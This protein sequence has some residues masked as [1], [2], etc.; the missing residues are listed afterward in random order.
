MVAVNR[1]EIQQIVINLLLNAEHAIGEQAGTIVMRTEA[2]D[3]TH[4]L[5]VIDSGPGI[6]PELRGRVFEPFFTTKE[7]GEGT[8]LGLSIA[9]GIARAHGGS[10]DLCPTVR[11]AC[12]Q[13]TL[14]ARPLAADAATT[15]ARVE[16]PA[17]VPAG[18]GA[19]SRHALVIDDEPA[20]R[21]LLTRLLANRDYSVT[22][23]RSFAEVQ[24]VSGLRQF[25]LVLCDLRL[26][27]ARGTDCLRHLR[28][29]QAGIDRRFVFM[30]GDVTALDNADPADAVVGLAVLSKP[31][32]ATDL[33]R[34]LGRVAATA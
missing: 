26:S 33:D 18:G 5:R 27:D 14:P 34:V 8:G 9:L 1:E 16:S 19:A 10:L 15:A 17:R 32:S 7:V 2:S 4:T 29:A 25:D 12:F 13:L 21:A 3:R 24:T 22:E 11:G 20:I 23:A 31:F 6:T 30:T 28:Q